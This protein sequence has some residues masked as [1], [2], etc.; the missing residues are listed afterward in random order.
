MRKLLLLI[1]ALPLSGY[2][3]QDTAQS[4]ELEEVLV[5]DYE[6]RA[7][8]TFKEQQ[9]DTDSLAEIGR[10]T[11]AEALQ[12]HTG[13]FVKSYGGNGVASLSLRGTGASHT[14]VFWNNAFY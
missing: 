2:S 11:L 5:T 12:N 7:N 1:L 9:M 8:T 13:I 14:K 3:Q 6:I 4:E 10:L